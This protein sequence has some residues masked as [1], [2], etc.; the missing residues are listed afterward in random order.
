MNKKLGIALAMGALQVSALAYS[1]NSVAQ[2]TFYESEGFQGRSFTTQQS[3]VNN[4]ERSGFNDRASS[5]VV[6][7]SRWEVCSDRRFG[8]DCMILRPGRY[9]SLASLGLNDRISSARAVSSSTRF[10]DSRYAPMPMAG[11]IIFFENEGFSGRTFT[12]ERQV[13]NFQRVGFNDRSSSV[14]VIG[15]RFEVCDDAGFRGQDHRVQMTSQPGPTV[16]VNEQG[17]PRT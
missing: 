2:V 10:D 14:E 6:V 5:A 7:G 12:T 1:V 9:P 16:T 17:E 15:E 3:N 11:Q 13:E 8:G 4:F